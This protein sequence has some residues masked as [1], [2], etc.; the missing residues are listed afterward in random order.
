MKYFDL[1][2]NKVECIAFPILTMLRMKLSGYSN[3]TLSLKPSRP[4]HMVFTLSRMASLLQREEYGGKDYPS[5]PR[6]PHTLL[7]LVV[8]SSSQC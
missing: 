7:G 1:H 8:C 4:I 6:K 5:T 3:T 2:Q